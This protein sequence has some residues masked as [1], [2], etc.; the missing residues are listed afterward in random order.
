MKHNL[1]WN[2][3]TPNLCVGAY[4]ESPEVLDFLK[5]EVGVTGVLNLQ[6]D[7]DLYRRAIHWNGMWKAYVGRGMEIVRV[8]IVDLKPADLARHLES[9]VKALEQLAK[10]HDQV[11][12]HCNV[13]LNRSPTV[14]IAYLVSQGAGIQEAHDL[15]MDA[16]EV[17]PYMDVV[18]GWWQNRKSL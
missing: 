15:V 8:P 12:V 2:R 13:G 18:E 5:S 14:A 16:R 1:S 3:I 10:R 9:A 4:P 6:S 17:V 11:Y 7:K